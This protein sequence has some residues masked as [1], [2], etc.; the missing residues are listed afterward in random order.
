M[1]VTR[2][3]EFGFWYVEFGTLEVYPNGNAK[4][5]SFL[6]QREYRFGSLIYE[7][8]APEIDKI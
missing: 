3:Y 2:E 4:Q 7:S 8:E 6:G 1:W 5:I